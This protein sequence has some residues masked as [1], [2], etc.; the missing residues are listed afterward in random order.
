MAVLC[1]LGAGLAGAALA[2][3]AP[4]CAQ[5]AFAQPGPLLA[6]TRDV[7]VDY[8]LRPRDHA[9]LEV[10][11]SIEAGGRHLRI[12]SEDLPTAFL[13][14]RPAQMATILLP[15]L[16]LYTTIG[17]G[18]FD[19]SETMLR[20]AHFER[21]GQEDL[22]GHVCTDWSAISP[23]GHAEGCITADGVILRGAATDRHGLIGSV[24]T[25]TVQFGGLPPEL[26]RRPADFQ[27]AG[28]LPIGSLVGGQP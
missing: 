2:G 8:T 25:T 14:D 4:A 23:Q 28:K 10:R 15:L 24:S 6:P 13:I 27:N 18:K 16:K 3:A 11:V 1:V 22:A 9:P 21:H 20:R 5:P 12:T 19:L 26:F 17:I 7:T